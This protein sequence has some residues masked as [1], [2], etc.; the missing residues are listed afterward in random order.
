LR[1]DETQAI[2]KGTRA[3]QDGATTETSRPTAREL[4]VCS[5]LR[6]GPVSE[7]LNRLNSVLLV[8]RT[9]LW[10]GYCW[11][12]GNIDE[13]GPGCGWRV[14]VVLLPRQPMRARCTRDRELGERLANARDHTPG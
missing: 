3:R 11:W 4:V 1:H 2:S 8:R 13:T 7:A 6:D 9:E 14:R 12:H 10:G 5:R